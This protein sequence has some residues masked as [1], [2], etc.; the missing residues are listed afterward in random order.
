MFLTPQEPKIRKNTTKLIR[1]PLRIAEN[2]VKTRVLNSAGPVEGGGRCRSRASPDKENPGP[3]PLPGKMNGRTREFYDAHPR[4]TRHSH[5]RLSKK[6]RKIALKYQ[7][8]SRTACHKLQ[9]ISTESHT[10]VQKHAKKHT[11]HEIGDS[12]EQ[13]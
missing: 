3:E 7:L 5:K 12:W 6:H 9:H 2:H 8:D 10:D 11:K 4:K 13:K 1:R